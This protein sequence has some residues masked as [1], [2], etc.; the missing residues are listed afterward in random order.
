[1]ACNLKFRTN[2]MV[3]YLATVISKL[4]SA[5]PD[6][7]PSLWEIAKIFVAVQLYVLQNISDDD[8]D[9]DLIAKPSLPYWQ[10]VLAY[11]C[12]QVLYILIL[13]SCFSIIADNI[14]WY[15]LFWPYI[16]TTELNTLPG[17]VLYRHIFA[18]LDNIITK[19]FRRAASAHYY[20]KLL[21]PFEHVWNHDATI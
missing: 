6:K 12:S 17:R 7:F 10:Y 8:D 3:Q 13:Y 16:P 19:L 15:I 14:N 1:M 21:A 20:K 9:Y 5:I 18:K 2:E 4:L 11:Y